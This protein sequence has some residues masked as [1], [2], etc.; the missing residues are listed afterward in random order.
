MTLYRKKQILGDI[1]SQGTFEEITGKIS[2]FEGQ[3][4]PCIM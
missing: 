3:G 4:K 1:M 2:L